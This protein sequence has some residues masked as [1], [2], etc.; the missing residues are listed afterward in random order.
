VELSFILGDHQFLGIAAQVRQGVNGDRDTFSNTLVDVLDRVPRQEV[1]DPSLFRHVEMFQCIV[2]SVEVEKDC[3]KATHGGKE[4]SKTAEEKF[5]KDYLRVAVGNVKGWPLVALG[6]GGGV[7]QRLE[8]RYYIPPGMHNQNKM[9]ESALQV[10]NYFFSNPTHR[11]HWDEVLEEI[12]A[13]SAR[14]E[15]NLNM[16]KLRALIQEY[17]ANFQCFFFFLSSQ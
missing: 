5:V 12:A 7:L 10:F 14:G 2:D 3:Y 13:R 9:S 15:I 8:Y 16:R 6:D 11:R 17:A 1:P 4:L